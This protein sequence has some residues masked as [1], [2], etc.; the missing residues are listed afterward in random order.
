MGASEYLST[1]SEGGGKSPRKASVYTTIAY[2]LTVLF[3]IAPFFLL[4]NYYMALGVT[5]LN[6]V[7]VIFVFTFYISVAKDLPFRR[8]FSEMAGIS[9][10]V[11]AVTFVIGML[12]RIFLGID[13]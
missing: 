13:I 2:M 12:V 1:K 4:A 6:A 9:L 8:R 3:L 10:G 11:A 7:I 5:V